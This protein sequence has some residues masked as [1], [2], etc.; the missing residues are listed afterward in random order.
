MRKSSTETVTARLERFKRVWE[1]LAPET[2]FGG[3]TLAEF[4]T[5]TQPSFDERQTISMLDA[6]RSAAIGRR[7]TADETSREKIDLVV[8]GV[9]SNPDHGADSA[10]YRALGY[11]P[12]SERRS[13]LTRKVKPAAATLVS[14]PKAA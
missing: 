13:G 12:K 5:A 4:T 2:S 10:F 6:L 9:R 11:T 3:M 8:N 7:A 14:L 1:E